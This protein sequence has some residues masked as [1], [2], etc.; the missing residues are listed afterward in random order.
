MPVTKTLEQQF[1]DCQNK[2]DSPEF[3]EACHSYAMSEHHVSEIAMR[4]AILTYLRYAKG[5]A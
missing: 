5:K 1:I 4:Q 2:V 3:A